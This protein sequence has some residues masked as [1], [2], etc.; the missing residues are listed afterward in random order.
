MRP[1]A[2]EVTMMRSNKMTDVGHELSSPVMTMVLR[3]MAR[4]SEV[5]PMVLTSRRGMNPHWSGC[6]DLLLSPPLRLGTVENIVIV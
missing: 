1:A 6:G 4:T 5:L 2:H 3:T